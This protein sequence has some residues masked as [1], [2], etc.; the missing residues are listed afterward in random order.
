MR[1]PLLLMHGVWCFVLTTLMPVAA[2]AQGAATVTVQGAEVETQKSMTINDAFSDYCHQPDASRWFCAERP[3][4]AAPPL[5]EA[6]AWEILNGYC[7]DEVG[8]TRPTAD[9]RRDLL[10]KLVAVKADT[11]LSPREQ[12]CRSVMPGVT[13]PLLFQYDHTS[14]K[15][16]SEI[17]GNQK[18]RVKIDPVTGLPTAW[19]VPGDQIGIVVTRT[20]PL[21][22]V[23]S[24]GTPKEE[25]IEQ[26]DAMARLITLAGAS[27][28]SALADFAAKNPGAAKQ[29]INVFAAKRAA[30]SSDLESIA[31]T[32]TLGALP[33]GFDEDE[34]EVGLAAVLIKDAVDPLRERLSRFNE[35]RSSLQL[36]SQSLEKGPS[37]F[38]GTFEQALESPEEWRAIFGGLRE[39]LSGTPQYEGCEALFDAF[40]PVVNLSVDKPND[41]H[42]AVLR[43]RRLRQTEPKGAQ[44]NC[45][46]KK[47]PATLEAAANDVGQ[48]AQAVARNPDEVFGS[49]KAIEELRKRQ[50]KARDDHFQNSLA[51]VAM[52]RGLG[53]RREAAT[54]MLEK[55]EATRKAAMALASIV[56]RTRDASFRQDGVGGLLVSDR[57]YVEEEVYESSWAKIRTTSLNVSISSP[58]ADQVTPAHP[59]DVATSYRMARQGADRFSVTVGIL[60]TTAA[61]PTYVAADPD[62]AS[63]TVVKTTTQ[64]PVT[65]G[66]STTETTQPELK[67]I[68]LKDE[69]SRA[70][71]FA[72]FAGWRLVGGDGVG[73]GVQGGVAV[74]TDKPA[75]LGGGYLNVSK[76]LMVGGGVGRFRVKQL[77]LGANGVL[78]AVDDPIGSTDDI[79]LEN[80]WIPKGYAVL[81][82]NILGLPLFS[83][84]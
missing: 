10:T 14:L 58:Y 28:P 52:T 74:S 44:P 61:S 30:G 68:T 38:H 11:P 83:S 12:F 76:W 21:I 2:A 24:R 79:K 20:N 66:T 67:R 13:Q 4:A 32:L 27:L 63:N 39:A 41:I 78:Q 56:T 31:S 15:W 19:L 25:N 26:F 35:L 23:A 16:G 34:R 72:I 64:T 8:Q 43:F 46:L 62:P 3:Q 48:M 81:S 22:Y 1:V 36:L 57:I 84:K 40:G 17:W 53:A 80:G 47:Y 18:R 71:Q 6:L 70:G 65:G 73:V 50:T 37:V 45:L 55:E 69:D 51:L 42:A 9:M 59:K 7:F 29:A 60:Y 49:G 82:V 77:G 54:Q 75:F 33:N 5:S